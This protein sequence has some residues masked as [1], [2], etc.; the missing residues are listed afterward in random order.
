MSTAG[1]NAADR[2]L[3]HPR[4]PACADGLRYIPAQDGLYETRHAAPANENPTC[5]SLE[6]WAAIKALTS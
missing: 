5:P 3:I 4:V 1:A 6:G 2:P